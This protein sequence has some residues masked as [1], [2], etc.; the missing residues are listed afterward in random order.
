[1]SPIS[2]IGAVAASGA[3]SPT[4]HALPIAS[5]GTTGTSFSS[6]LMN[7]VNGVNQKLV[8]ADAMARAFALDDSIPVHQVTFALEQARLSFEL[9][10]QVRS[11]L[12]DAYQE[13]SRMQL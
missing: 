12:V 10:L 6:L 8:N 3:L 4:V 7:G 1:M 9:M 13:F 11:K 5:P 2:A